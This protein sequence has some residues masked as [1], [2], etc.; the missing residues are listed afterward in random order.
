[1]EK[2]P[3]YWH[4]GDEQR[5][6]GLKMYKHALETEPGLQMGHRKY[7]FPEDVMHLEAMSADILISHEAPKSPALEDG[8]D[9]LG[10]LARD[11][12]VK[13]VI[14]GHH[15]RDYQTEIADGIAVLGVGRRSMLRLDLGQYRSTVR[16]SM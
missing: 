3:G 12:G 13:A 2:K 9:V 10:R 16:L 14:H 5:L 1:M 11:M 15:H 6:K 7:I 8:F 4:K